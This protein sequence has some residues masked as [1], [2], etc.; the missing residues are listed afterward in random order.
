MTRNHL[1]VGSNP[2]GPTIYTN[3]LRRFSAMVSGQDIEEDET[4]EAKANTDEVEK[5]SLAPDRLHREGMP[6]PI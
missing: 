1:V 5:R 4:E 2:T 3:G 6:Q